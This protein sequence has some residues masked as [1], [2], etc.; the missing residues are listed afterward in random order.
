MSTI[1]IIEY[2]HKKIFILEFIF[3]Y[4]IKKVL[5]ISG[6]KKYYSLYTYKKCRNYK[7]KEKERS[8]KI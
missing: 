8:Y 2:I 5:T 7:W 6:K 4:H 3:G 1:I